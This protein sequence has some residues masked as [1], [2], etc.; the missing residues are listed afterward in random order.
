[1]LPWWLKHHV[2]LFDYGVMIDHGSTDGSADIIRS[3]A[4][5][6]RLVH[7]NLMSFD[8][9]LT[10]FEVMS[11][12]KEVPGWKI[13]LNV[14]EFL[15]PTTSLD[16][17]EAQLSAS[18]KN[19]CAC[20]GIICVD[21]KSTKLPLHDKPLPLQKHWGI[22]DNIVQDFKDRLT[23]GLSRYPERNRF[24]HCNSVGMYHPGRHI[25]FHPDSM[26][27]LLD[28][29]IFTFTF[30][31]WNEKAINRKLQIKARLNP[32]DV[33]RGWGIQHIKDVSQWELEYRHIRNFAIDLYTHPHAAV[34]LQ[35]VVK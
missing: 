26:V 12:E 32:D 4:P 30:A 14:T 25:S 23:I 7:S 16:V 9:Y 19:G 31:P 13:V 34:A 33:N 15:M 17:I 8:A 6:W 10:D 29:M 11:Y 2:S 21:D 28:L 24:Y 18:G 35:Q 27:R 22:D 3:L 5:H 1:M 20:S